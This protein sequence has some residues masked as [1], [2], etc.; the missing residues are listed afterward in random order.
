VIVLRALQSKL[1]E[2]LAQV[3]AA[4]SL[5]HLRAAKASVAGDGLEP[6]L[7]LDLARNIIH[8]CASTTAKVIL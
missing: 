3:H 8:E 1:A 7:L 6:S 5:L 2:A 4:A